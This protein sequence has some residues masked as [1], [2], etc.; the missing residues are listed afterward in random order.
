MDSTGCAPLPP[1]R[2]TRPYSTCWNTRPHSTSCNIRPYSTRCDTRPC[3]PYCRTTFGSRSR[4]GPVLG[5]YCRVRPG[6]SPRPDPR[7]RSWLVSACPWPDIR[8]SHAMPWGPRPLCG[9]T[10]RDVLGSFGSYPLPHGGLSP[11]TAPLAGPADQGSTWAPL[12]E[13]VLNYGSFGPPGE[14]LFLRPSHRVDPC[15]GLE[16]L[17]H[18]EYHPPPSSFTSSSSLDVSETS[19][20]INHLV[21][22]WQLACTT[23]GVPPARDLAGNYNSFY[24]LPCN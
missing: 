24:L 13:P 3:P 19:E 8:G 2:N 12:S 17:P 9:S 6:R 15:S 18:L 20:I 5:Y 16:L 10:R 21:L 11:W 1:S 7:L 4:P 14:R 23:E 22:P